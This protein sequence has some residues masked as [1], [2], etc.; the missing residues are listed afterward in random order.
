MLLS[1]L[2][3]VTATSIA[4]EEDELTGEDEE[5]ELEELEEL[6]D[7]M[8]E[9]DELVEAVT[10]LVA[11]LEIGVLELPAFEELLEVI[12]PHEAKRTN[13]D[14]LHAKR[15]VCF[16]IDEPPLKNSQVSIILVYNLYQYRA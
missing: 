12:P 16:L 13:D 7:E 2:I 10:E 11:L 4:E 1:T 3:E 8:L 6:E 5:D 14:K 9:E 15:N